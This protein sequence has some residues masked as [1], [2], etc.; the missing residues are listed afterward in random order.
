MITD[1]LTSL[2]INS[3]N[4]AVYNNRL[5]E[6]NKTQ[7]RLLTDNASFH[8]KIESNKLSIQNDKDAIKK[9]IID[10]EYQTKQIESQQTTVNSV[11]TKLSNIK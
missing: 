9:N 4:Y 6:E 10:Q 3:P 2:S 1:S 8:K 5:K 11:R 7:K